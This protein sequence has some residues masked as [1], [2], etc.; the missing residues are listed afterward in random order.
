M[1]EGV[2]DCKASETFYRIPE[3]GI[4]I[5]SLDTLAF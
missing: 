2:A 3:S 1:A 4:F 5:S